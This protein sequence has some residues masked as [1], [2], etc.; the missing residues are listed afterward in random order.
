M[1]LYELNRMHSHRHPFVGDGD[2]YEELIGDVDLEEASEH[3]YLDGDVDGFFGE[4]DKKPATASATTQTVRQPTTGATKPTAP[5]P[6]KKPPKKDAGFD[7]MTVVSPVVAG[8]STLAIAYGV[9]RAVQIEKKKAFKVG[10]IMGGFA[11]VSQVFGNWLKDKIEDL[12]KLQNEEELLV[13]QTKA[14]T[15]G[16]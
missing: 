2:D 16:T 12:Q 13:A 8:V 5:K 6:P 3:I 10:Y 1:P 15:K 14:A 11:A 4:A 9:A 7:V